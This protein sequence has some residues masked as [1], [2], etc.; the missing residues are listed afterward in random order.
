LVKIKKVKNL[1]NVKLVKDTSFTIR[2]Q[3]DI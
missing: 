1:F 2:S 3:A